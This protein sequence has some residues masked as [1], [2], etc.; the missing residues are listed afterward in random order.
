[1]YIY[2]LTICQQNGTLWWES[3]KSLSETIDLHL[4]FKLKHILPEIAAVCFQPQD[5]CK[6]TIFIQKTTKYKNLTLQFILEILSLLGKG[7]QVK[8]TPFKLIS[9]SEC[10]K[11]FQ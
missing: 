5:S 8:V 3:P 2:I 1:M 6:H 7:A 11:I 4:N 10:N 9:E